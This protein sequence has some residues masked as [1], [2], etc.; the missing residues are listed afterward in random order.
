MSMLDELLNIWNGVMCI[1][2]GNLDYETEG[3]TERMS[4]TCGGTKNMI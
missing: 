3:G 1:V 4:Q 2:A